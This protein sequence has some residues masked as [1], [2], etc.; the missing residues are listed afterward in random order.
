MFQ[1]QSVLRKDRVRGADYMATGQIAVGGIAGLVGTI[2]L[3]QPV[4]ADGYFLQ[5]DVGDETQ[6]L[7]AT[8][9]TGALNFGLN[10]SNY[11]D[12]SSAVTSLTYALP[13]DDVAVLKLG[14]SV[15]VLHENG[16]WE[17]PELGAKLSLERYLGTSFGSVYGLA[18]FN[19]IDNAWFLLGQLTFQQPGL[20]LE[21]SRGGSDSYHETTVAVQKKLSDGPM[22]L[23]AGYKLSSEEFFIG[24]NI[25]TF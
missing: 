8:A 14:P 6:S 20:S 5:A 13:L 15:G 18:E 16:T 24:F 17:S 19:S 4:F 25:N 1:F 11:D 21:L 12:G 3:G 22:S 9:A 7:V 10:L 23:R 2:C